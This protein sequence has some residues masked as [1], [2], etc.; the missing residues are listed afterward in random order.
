MF[1]YFGLFG[2]QRGC[3]SEKQNKEKDCNFICMMTI[4]LLD[5]EV[6]G[7]IYIANKI[8]RNHNYFGNAKTKNKISKI[9]IKMK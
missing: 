8:E 3:K 7:F 9:K 4:I 1:V 6:N 2:V 5:E